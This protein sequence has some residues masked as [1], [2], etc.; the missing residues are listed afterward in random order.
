MSEEE[1]ELIVREVDTS[2]DGKVDFTE[3]RLMYLSRDFF[4]WGG[5]EGGMQALT[6]SAISNVFV[7]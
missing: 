6:G 4:C 7:F 5:R 1:V 2:Q 3:V